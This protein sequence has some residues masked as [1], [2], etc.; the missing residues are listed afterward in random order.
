MIHGDFYRAVKAPPINEYQFLQMP[1]SDSPNGGLWY[2]QNA[3]PRGPIVNMFEEAVRIAL[4][5]VRL[6]GD[7]PF[8]A[9][10]GDKLQWRCSWS[11][12][13]ALECGTPEGSGPPAPRRPVPHWAGR[14]GGR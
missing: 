7:T 10:D 2:V 13:D 8:A 1:G 4:L 14:A 9:G 11:D 5:I 6:R 3:H 12:Q